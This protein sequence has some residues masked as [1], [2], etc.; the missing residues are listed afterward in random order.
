L[1]DSA[2]IAFIDADD[3]WMPQ[4]LALQ[5]Q[6]FETARRPL[7]FVHSSVF[8]IDESGNALPLGNSAPP[9]L[10]G[11]VFSKLLREGN[12]LSGSASSVLIKRDV[13]D[14]AGVFDDQLNYGEDWDLWLRLAA[15]SEVDHTPEAVVGVRVHASS[16]QH[17]GNVAMDRF[18]QRIRV[19]SR[20]ERSIKQDRAFLR[21]LRRDGFHAVLAHARSVRE[22]HS[23][24][25]SIKAS[26]RNFAR[27]LYRN[28]LHYWLGLV[29]IKCLQLVVGKTRRHL[30][31][32]GWIG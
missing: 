25:R 15:I 16:A 23:F 5:M 7:G 18:L 21:R 29:S 8:L 2:F 17:K 14:A 4:K 32:F 31:D 11:N 26:Q 3:I 28:Q 20:W 22:A 27:N 19:Y 6:V 24:Y 1:S 30:R 10:R 9:L 12:V 13:L